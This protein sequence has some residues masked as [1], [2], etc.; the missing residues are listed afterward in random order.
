VEPLFTNSI[1]NILDIG[2]FYTKIITSL[3]AKIQE[4]GKQCLMFTVDSEQDIDRL[5]ERVLQYQVDGIIITAAALS[6]EMANLCV[7]NDTPI[8]LFNRFVPG[9]N[10][11]SVYC[12]NI[13]AGRAVAQFLAEGGHKNIA[14]TY[15]FSHFIN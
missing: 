6:R 1:F 7:Q 10:A 11:S 5:L 2:P 9:L 13:E 12:D 4:Q 8:V 15:L 3:T 14:H